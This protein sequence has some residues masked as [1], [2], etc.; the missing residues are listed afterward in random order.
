MSPLDIPGWE[1]GVTSVTKS[2]QESALATSIRYCS[3]G[4]TTKKI[5]L[6]INFFWM[7][8]L[9]SRYFCDQGKYKNKD[10]TDSKFPRYDDR[11]P[12]VI[13]AIPAIKTNDE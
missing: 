8:Y 11:Q 5:V 10:M 12:D 7:F 2:I 1:K 13:V 9:N 4:L 3:T 6:S